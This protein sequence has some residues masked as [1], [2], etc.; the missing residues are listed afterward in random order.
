M[1]LLIKK[2]LREYK[3]GLNEDEKMTTDDFIEKAQKVHQD[4]K[5]QPIYKYDKVDY[6]N[7]KKKVTITCPIHGD[8]EQRAGHHLAGKGCKDCGD[9][10][11]FQKRTKPQ[12][13]FIAQAKEKHG[14]KYDYS[15]VDYQGKNKDVMIICPKH[16]H[17]FD[18]TPDNHL[19]GEGCDLCGK[20]LNAQKR[21]KTMEEFLA[22][23]KAVHGDKYNYDKVVYKNI[24]SPVEIICK[25]HGSFMQTPYTHINQ[26]AGCPICQESKGEKMTAEILDSLGIEYKKEHK[27]DDCRGTS[28]R[29]LSFDFYLPKLNALIEYDGIQHFEPISGR[30]DQ[31][32]GIVQ[33]DGI[34][35]DFTKRSK[36]PL[37]RIPY[38]YNTNELVAQQIQKFLSKLKK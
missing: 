1:K 35:N 6:Q 11:R 5:G 33:R 23:A 22:Q 18:Q 19:R 37:L 2:I 17:I 15:L 9:I 29:K 28:C 7:N 30:E 31:Y 10:S 3:E 21:R 13:V 27:F 14:D 32:E 8:F 34:K 20:E 36:I 26:K 38:V 25:K 16:N 4:E 24:D 12:E